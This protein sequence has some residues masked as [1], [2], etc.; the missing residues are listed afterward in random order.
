MFRPRSGDECTTTGAGRAESPDTRPPDR[1]D[2]PAVPQS[3]AV[4]DLR[5]WSRPAKRA[6]IDRGHELCLRPRRCW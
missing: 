2:A 6:A 4:Q 3:G 1:T 5:P